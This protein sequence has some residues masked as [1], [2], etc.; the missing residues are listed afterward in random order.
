[1]LSSAHPLLST[2]WFFE[3][4]FPPINSALHLNIRVDAANLNL[5][6]QSVLMASPGRLFWGEHWPAT[7]ALL[8]RVNALN[9]QKIGFVFTEASFDYA[10][11]FLLRKP[12]RAFAHV[13]VAN[14]SRVLEDPAFQPDVIIAEKNEG[15]GFDYHEKSYRLAMESDGKWLYVPIK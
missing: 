10:Y 6:Q 11:Q 3:K 9:P 4:I 14:P 2:K 1:M 15:A 13:R 8:R 12:S 5:K 7:E